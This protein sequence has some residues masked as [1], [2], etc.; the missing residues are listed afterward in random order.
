MSRLKTVVVSVSTL[1]VAL[2]LVGAMLGKSSSDDGAYRQLSVYME[3]LSRI[4]ADYVEEPDLKSV[5]LGAVNG[6]LESIDP[7]ASYLNSDQYKEYLKTKDKEKGNV[8]LLLSKRMGSVNVVDAIPGSP[9]AKAGLTTF[10]MIESIKGIA[11]RDMPLAYAELLL[12]G[13][14]GTNVELSVLSMRNAEPRKVTL[15]RAVVQYPRVT[16][17]LLPDGVGDIQVESMNQGT[18]GEVARAVKSLETQGAKRFVLDLRHC[19]AGDLDEGV[20]VANLFQDKGTITYLKGQRIAKQSWDADPSKVVT[21]LPVAVITN[22]GTAGAAEIAAAA[23]EDN[24]RAQVV[25]ERTYGSAS[26]RQAISMD[27]G[28]AIILS[29]AKYYSPGGKA[30]QDNGVVPNVQVAE[31]EPLELEPEEAQPAPEQ[32][33]P[34]AKPGEDQ[35]LK[36]AIE[37]LTKG[38]AETAQKPEGPA[39]GA[40]SVVNPPEI[41]TPDSRVPQRPKQ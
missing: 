8:G 20:G 12:Q 26:L 41:V 10:D 19:A 35:L 29:V 28:G 31:A 16:S 24:K 27:D 17:K 32:Q 21:R 15:T 23:L 33:A 1:L 34:P 22:H 4:K 11:T 3:V 9:A 13:A 6:L 38:V 36:R 2:L 18:A 5:T 39:P 40:G 14:P 7:Y 25:G 37:V 30:I